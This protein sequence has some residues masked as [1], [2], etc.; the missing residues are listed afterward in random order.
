MIRRIFPVLRT[1][2]VS[3]AVL[4]LLYLSAIVATG[5]LCN[6]S[7]GLGLDRHYATRMWLPQRYRPGQAQVRA[8][9]VAE[10]AQGALLSSRAGAHALDFLLAFWGTSLVAG[11]VLWLSDRKTRHAPP[12]HLA[13]TI[14]MPT[15]G[16]KVLEFRRK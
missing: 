12:R 1:L 10:E 7:H 11:A 16:A 3:M 4:S 9:V 15:R 13:R 6:H 14:E 8:D 5:V 2:Y